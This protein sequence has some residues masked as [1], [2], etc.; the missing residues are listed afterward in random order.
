MSYLAGFRALILYLCF[1]DSLFLG[2]DPLRPSE[3]GNGRRLALERGEKEGFAVRSEAGSG[4]LDML[5]N[6]ASGDLLLTRVL[7]KSGLK[8]GGQRRRVDYRGMN[9]V[10]YKKISG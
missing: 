1:F 9:A 7:L 10:T 8:M 2:A 5:L 4:R 6:L 3:A